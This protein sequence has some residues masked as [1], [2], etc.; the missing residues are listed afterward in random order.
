M[1]EQITKRRTHWQALAHRKYRRMEYVG[2]DG[3]WIG[4]IMCSSRWRYRLFE[5]RSDAEAWMAEIDAKGCGHYGNYTC[6]GAR[7]HRMWRIIE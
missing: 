1:T 2:G 7:G 5:Y 6:K 3:E 4:C